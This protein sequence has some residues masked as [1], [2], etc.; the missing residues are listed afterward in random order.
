MFDLLA[1]TPPAA[2]GSARSSADSGNPNFTEAAVSGG[3]QN[4]PCSNVES[5]IASG[6]DNAGQTQTMRQS[7]ERQ[8]KCARTSEHVAGAVP[9]QTSDIHPATAHETD[10]VMEE[11]MAH[12]SSFQ[13]Q[14]FA[15][16]DD[17]FAWQLKRPAS[18]MKR[19][20]AGL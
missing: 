20:A 7:E 14:V 15:T 2:S 12:E 8:A 6:T 4:E 5:S 19:P 10:A 13:S 18:G 9:E 16:G 17:G 1:A 11:Y 3:A